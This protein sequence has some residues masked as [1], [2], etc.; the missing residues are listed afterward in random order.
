VRRW[1]VVFLAAAAAVLSFDALR[2]HAL[3]SGVIPTQAIMPRTWLAALWALVIDA[4]AAAG[5][6]GVRADRRDP[7]AW[8]MLILA[9][10]GS[11]GFQVWT[12]PTELARAVPPVV[13]ALAI[14][15]LE[16]PR[17]TAG[18]FREAAP[19][20]TVP[21]PEVRPP[22]PPA[23]AVKPAPPGGALEPAHRAAIAEL[24]AG[25]GERKV[26][27]GLGARG[28]DL[29]RAMVRRELQRIRDNGT[30]PHEEIPAQ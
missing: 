18:A 21:A 1:L 16:L 17:R 26:M 22:S 5:I 23:R 10:A 19:A 7:R 2:A 25:G 14:I 30:A 13:L 3:E 29:P 12:P 28:I 27:A 20:A 8:T 6:L 4:A 24:A 15:V 9:F 11:V